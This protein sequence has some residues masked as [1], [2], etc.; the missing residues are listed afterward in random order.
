MQ[1]ETIYTFKNYLYIVISGFFSQNKVE[2]I[3]LIPWGPFFIKQLFHSRLVGYEMIIANSALRASLAVYHLSYP[4]RAREIIVK[5]QLRNWSTGNYQIILVPRAAILGAG[6]EDRSSGDENVG[7]CIPCLETHMRIK[8]TDDIEN[9][10][11]HTGCNIYGKWT[12]LTLKQRDPSCMIF[13]PWYLSLLS[14][15]PISACQVTGISV[16]VSSGMNDF[17]ARIS[18]CITTLCS[19]NKSRGIRYQF[20]SS[21][22]SFI[23]RQI[24]VRTDCFQN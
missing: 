8:C 1:V 21:I 10:F 16:K 13:G 12:K 2:K 24:S 3:C 5:K 6:Q 15:C 9:K 18:W 11:E 20:N 14:S 17:R 22:P 19:G 4:T 23:H 7:S